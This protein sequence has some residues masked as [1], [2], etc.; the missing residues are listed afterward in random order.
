VLVSTHILSEVEATC[1]RAIIVI[2]GQLM[3]DAKLSELS[4]TANAMLS[5][6]TTG[7]EDSIV[8][9][10][11]QLA[12]VKKAEIVGQPNGRATFRIHGSTEE[13]LCPALYRLAKENDW[14]LCELRRDVRTLE[15][16]FNELTM[17]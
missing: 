15:S 9:I 7:Q 14:P 12:G 5:L 2:R 13:D 16:V 4:A 1:D 17:K 11:G 6:E 10:L 8:K 3:A